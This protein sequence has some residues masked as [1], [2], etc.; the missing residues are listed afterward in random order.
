[1]RPPDPREWAYQLLPAA[2]V[3]RTTSRSLARYFP[4]VL[5]QGAEG[6]CTANSSVTVQMACASIIGL[7][8]VL[9]SREEL[10][11]DERTDEGGAQAPPADNGA[12]PADSFDS[13]LK[14]NGIVADTTWG[15]DGKP[16]TKPPA[17]VAKA[18]R[19]LYIN[20]HQPLAGA[21]FIDGII[22]ALDNQQ[23]LIVAFAFYQEWFG[24][25]QKNGVLSGTPVG[26]PVG[27][28]QIAAWG[29]VPSTET[30]PALV[31]CRNSW[32]ATSPARTDLH[33]DAVAGDIFLPVALF[34]N[35]I[36]GEVRAANHPAAPLPTPTPTPTPTCKAQMDAGLA[37]LALAAHNAKP[38][39]YYAE[40]LVN[41]WI[42]PF[43]DQVV[44]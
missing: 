15:Y 19:Y 9:L 11:W 8:P 17:A 37:A 26:Q 23:P 38:R 21:N 43:L 25:Y 34:Q 27:G 36:V 35:G 7:T 29:W 31:A 10:Y 18:Q 39:A 40:T 28:H 41:T 1:M 3:D 20:G 44:S 42:K 30:N 33:P 13:V 4:S 22:T 12:Y 2:A 5:D 6:S 32:G 14:R 24:Q 16:A